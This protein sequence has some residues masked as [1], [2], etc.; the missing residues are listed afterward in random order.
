MDKDARPV[1]T[2][3]FGDATGWLSSSALRFQEDKGGEQL[4]AT[5]LGI[6]LPVV[7]FVVKLKCLEESGR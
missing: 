2:P 5:A 3:E 1:G 4:K 6:T 7:S